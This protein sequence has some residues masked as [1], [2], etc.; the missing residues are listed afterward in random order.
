MAEINEG[1]NKGTE[2]WDVIVASFFCCVRWSIKLLIFY[3]I[4]FCF[5]ALLHTHPGVKI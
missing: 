2:I 5:F 3:L 1:A 4:V